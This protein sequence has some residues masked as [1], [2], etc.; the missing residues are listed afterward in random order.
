MVI[1]IAALLVGGAAPS[2]PYGPADAR[3]WAKS[4]SARCPGHNI[5]EWIAPG[6][7]SDLIDSYAAKLPRRQSQSYRRLA[8]V[9][10]VCGAADRWGQSCDV[11]VKRHTLRQMGLLGSFA[12]F[13]CSRAVC[14][15]VSDC[16]VPKRRTR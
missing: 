15:D 1:L 8:E 9:G 6:A 2:T 3:A 10:R 13:A 5:Y 14:T 16:H 11:I 4:L 7:E 12:G